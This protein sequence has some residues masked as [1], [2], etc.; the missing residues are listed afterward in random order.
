[1]DGIQPKIT[2]LQ[3]SRIICPTVKRKRIHQNQCRGDLVSTLLAGRQTLSPHVDTAPLAG[4]LEGDMEKTAGLAEMRP[5]VSTV[6]S[7]SDGIK[8]RLLCR[9][10]PHCRWRL[11]EMKHRKSFPGSEEC[12][13]SRAALS[14]QMRPESESQ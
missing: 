7:T 8:G 13:L 14:A 3:R 11:S 10:R 12:P 4:K 6:K 5:A 9:G 1:M 2:G